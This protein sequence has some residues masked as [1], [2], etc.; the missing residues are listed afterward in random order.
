MKIQFLQYLKSY[1]TKKY[2]FKKNFNIK[3]NFKIKI[4]DE[5]TC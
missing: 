2:I 5:T 4:K 3:K 1:K